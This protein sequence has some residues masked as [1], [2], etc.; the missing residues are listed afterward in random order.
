MKISLLLR[1]LIVASAVS[2]CSDDGPSSPSGDAAV[3]TAADTN[4]YSHCS[5][6]RLLYDRPGCGAQTPQ[7]L[8]LPKFP[9]DAAAKLEYLCSCDG[10]NIGAVQGNVSFEPYAYAGQCRMGDAGG[11]GPGSADVMP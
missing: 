9:E 11:D 6:G 1:V 8:C 7:P 4:P 2:A 10:Q 3:D 5:R